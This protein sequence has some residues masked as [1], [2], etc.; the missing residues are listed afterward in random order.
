MNSRLRAVVVVALPDERETWTLPAAA[1][2]RSIPANR[3]SAC[4]GV[5]THDPARERSS[6]MAAAALAAN[7]VPLSWRWPGFQASRQG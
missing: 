1:V 3:L 2:S 6:L 5:C 7:P 4:H